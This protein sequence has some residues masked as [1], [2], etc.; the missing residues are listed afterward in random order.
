MLF[1]SSVARALCAIG[2]AAAAA[3]ASGG[4]RLAAGEDHLLFTRADGSLWAAGADQSGQLGMEGGPRSLPAAVAADS[5]FARVSAGAGYSLALRAD[6]S[7]WAFGKNASA[8]LGV[9][10]CES[11]AAPVRMDT[12]IWLDAAAGNAVSLGIRADS[13]LILWGDWK[14]LVTNAGLASGRRGRPRQIGAGA[15]KAI[16]MGGNHALALRGDGSLWAMGADDAGQT[17]CS[18]SV[19]VRTLCPVAAPAEAGTEGPMAWTSVAAGDHF[20]LGIRA[21]GSLWSWGDNT[22]GELGRGTFTDWEDM[23]RVGTDKWL[24]VSAGS[25]HVLALR[26]D[27]TLWSWGGGGDGALGTGSLENAPA[28][29]LLGYDKWIEA[30]AGKGFSVALRADGEAMIWGR[31]GFMRAPGAGGDPLALRPCYLERKL[32]VGPIGPAIFGGRDL[33]LAYTANHWDSVTVTSSSPYLLLPVAGGIHPLAAGRGTMTVK[34][35]P[36]AGSG[37]DT[38]SQARTVTVAKARQTLSFPEPEPLA[39]GS[40]LLPGAVSSVGLPIGFVSLDRKVVRVVGDH[41]ETVAPGVAEV[42]AVQ[43]GDA[44]TLAAEYVTRKITVLP[45][46]ALVRPQAGKL[47]AR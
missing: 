43:P 23:G 35:Y 22:L 28:P 9:E 17:G 26:A 8:Q 29:V 37:Q 4:G 12:N 10:R 46:E 27:S 38:L 33:A 30:A 47:S 13:A 21:D 24:A 36:P 3:A 2:M 14:S 31:L 34:A 41:L 42:T 25:R 5:A 11:I 19:A 18:D 6:G 1:P 15:W 7:L 20:S 16:S 40:I 45:T 32:T 44:N 39:A